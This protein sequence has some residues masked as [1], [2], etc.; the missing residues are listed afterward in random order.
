S[1]P[2]AIAL[3]TPNAKTI[4]KNAILRTLTLPL[5]PKIEVDHQG[6][7]KC[8]G[9]EQSRSA[10]MR[11]ILRRLR[12]T[13]PGS[14]TQRSVPQAFG[15]LSD[16]PV[17]VI[18]PFGPLALFLEGRELVD[19]VPRHRPFHDRSEGAAQRVAEIFENL[20]HA[21]KPAKMD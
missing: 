21:N 6:P 10:I 7:S 8:G 2:V 12:V 16:A 11:E 4:E 17:A 1:E 9:I 13:I 5:S 19:H 15:F 18:E 3:L 14:A 20:A